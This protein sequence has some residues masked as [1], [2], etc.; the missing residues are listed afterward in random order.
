M[1]DMMTR[2]RLPADRLHHLPHFVDTAGVDPKEVPGADAVIAGRLSKEKGVDVAI[3]AA[4]GFPDGLRLQVAGDGPLRADL[5]RLAAAEAPGKVTFHGRLDKPTLLRLLRSSSV[6]L[7]PSTWYENQP[8]A[9]LE[10]FACGLPVVGTTLGGVPEL[11]T[12]GVDGLLVPPG[13]AVSLGAAVTSIATDRELAAR[14]G[15]AGRARVERDFTPGAH[16]EGLVS[17][18]ALAADHARG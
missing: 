15:A 17:L 16:L 3:R 7:V 1:Q 5:E 12:P 4:A 14:M 10:A 6:A 11:V 8:M 13:D 9:V 18:Y 2:G